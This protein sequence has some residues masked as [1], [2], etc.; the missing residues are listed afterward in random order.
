MDN[1]GNPGDDIAERLLTFAA[2]V[3]IL[4]DELP[5]TRLGRHIA[6]QFVR[7]GTVPAF[8]YAEARS[9]ESR[10]DL[11]HKLSTCLKELEESYVCLLLVNKAKLLPPEAIRDLLQECGELKKIIGKSI[12]T[13]KSRL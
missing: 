4:V 10:K 9:A 5:N 2:N 3:G 8:H 11:I 13:A 7:C 12:S 1:C 6:G